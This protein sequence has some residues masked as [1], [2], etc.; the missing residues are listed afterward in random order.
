[1]KPLS[2]DKS[3]QASYQAVEIFSQWSNFENR[4]ESVSHLYVY[5][6]SFS[7][8]FIIWIHD[9]LLSVKCSLCLEPTQIV[10]G[11]VSFENCSI[12]G[13]SEFYKLILYN[14]DISKLYFIGLN[15]KWR[16][17]TEDHLLNFQF[18]KLCLTIIRF[19][20]YKKLRFASHRRWNGH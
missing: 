11:P 8:F 12:V 14:I 20:T 6:Q 13:E 16:V 19:I 7:R 10:I 1:M 5:N 3:N 15:F 18:L 2:Y 9:G 17:F 4:F